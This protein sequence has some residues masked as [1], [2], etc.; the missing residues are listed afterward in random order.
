[1]SVRASFL[2]VALLALLPAIARADNAVASGKHV[3]LAANCYL[4]H[5]TAGQGGAGP[6]IVPPRLM[7]SL[8]AFTAWVRAPGPGQMPVYTAK[9]LG[10]AD[11]AAIYAYLASL[12]AP[13]AIPPVLLHP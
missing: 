10:D 6:T 3:F 2:T 5:G 7:P 8:A 4:C 1:M 13:A 9:V 12:K 11:L